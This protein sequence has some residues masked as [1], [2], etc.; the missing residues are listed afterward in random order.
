MRLKPCKQFDCEVRDKCFRYELYQAWKKRVTPI[1]YERT[2][3][4]NQQMFLCRPK[5]TGTKCDHFIKVWSI[6][7]KDTNKLSLEYLKGK[8]K[9][10]RYERMKQQRGYKILFI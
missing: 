5:H 7:Y 8:V 2:M 1:M 4:L 10:Y 6:H 9:A 3:Q